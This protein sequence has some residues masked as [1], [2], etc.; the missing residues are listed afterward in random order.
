MTPTADEFQAGLLAMTPLPTHQLAM[1]K[2][3]YE[4][5]RHTITATRIADALQYDGWRGVNLHYGKFCVVLA[6][7]MRRPVGEATDLAL[8]LAGPPVIGPN[9]QLD[10][11]L[12]P[13]LVEALDRLC[14]G[15]AS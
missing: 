11:V 9:G 5:P 2:A 8:I 13:E 4:A 12:R 3:H 7:R 6:E 10:L 15:W 14:W 1:L